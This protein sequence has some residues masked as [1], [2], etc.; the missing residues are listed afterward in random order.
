[1]KIEMR[2][3]A[4]GLLCAMTFMGCMMAVTNVNNSAGARYEVHWQ[5]ATSPAAS[6]YVVL[7]TQTGTT[8]TWQSFPHGE[9]R[10]FTPAP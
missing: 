7:D 6:Y 8:I 9:V 4:I 1:M 10:A 5:E 2:S 3:F